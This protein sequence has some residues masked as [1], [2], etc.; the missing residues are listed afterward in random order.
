MVEAIDANGIAEASGG[1]CVL[2][3]LNTDAVEDN[4]HITP[5]IK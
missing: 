4:V 3:G 5:R 1:E 2:K